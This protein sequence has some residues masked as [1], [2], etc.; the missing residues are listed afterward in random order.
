MAESK[1]TDEGQ[2]AIP[3]EILRKLGVGPGATLEWKEEGNRVYVRPSVR[4]SW[5]E[6]HRKVFPDGPP[7]PR[8]LEELKEAIPK[9]MREKYGRRR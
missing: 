4:E 2:I 7:E 1:I 8:T 6:L 3:E 9:Y 5:E